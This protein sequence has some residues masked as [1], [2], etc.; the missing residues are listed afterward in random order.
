MIQRFIGRLLRSRLL[1]VCAI[2]AVA[3]SAF[4][5]ETSNHLYKVKKSDTLYGIAHYH[6]ITVDQLIN[7]NPEMKLPG[8]QLHKGD[9][10]YIPSPGNTAA[11]AKNPS[12]GKESLGAKQSK[13]LRVGI[14]LPLHNVDGDGRRMVEY[15]RGVLLAC[16]SLK[17][18][19]YSIDIHSWNLDATADP[20]LVTRDPAAAQC[21]IIFGPLYS[22]QVHA[23]AE[24]CKARDIKLVIPFSISGD[25]VTS[26]SQIFQIWQSDDK[27]NNDAIE[28][29]LK[30]YKDARVVLIDCNDKTS[31]KGNFTFGLRNRLSSRGQEYRVTNLNSSLETF[32]KA[33]DPNR[34]NVV[35]LNTG[36]SPELNQSIAKL[37]ALRAQQHGLRMAL[38]GYNEWLMY[39]PGNVDTFC[40]FDTCVPTY[41]YYNDADPRTK[42][43]EADYQKWFHEK[44]MYA[45]PRFF[46]TGYDHA[47]FFLRGMAKYGKSF[48]GIAGQSA[49]RAYQTPL[50]FK[51]V[52]DKGMQNDNFQLIHF[53]T[54]GRIESLTY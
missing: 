1:M 49:Y 20:A 5:Q 51:Q 27:L 38:F 52:G 50:V 11:T 34:L 33:F 43:L 22:T 40:S 7:A 19:G 42:R 41:Y 25:D 31:K 54:G 2:F 48:T 12:T 18:A 28:A 47:Q 15:Y 6:G 8:Y 16:D 26:Y 39:A 9:R 14:A 53:A 45:Y 29:F 4:A 37:R 13:I 30:R 21:N 44:P 36:R 24:F 46:L 23:L 32:A 17:R 10:L 35:V 3:V